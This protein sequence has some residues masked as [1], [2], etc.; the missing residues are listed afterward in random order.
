MTTTTPPALTRRSAGTARV[1]AAMEHLTSAQLELRRAAMDLGAVTGY[2]VEHGTIRSLHD[3]SRAA[4]NM[5]DDK[6]GGPPKGKTGELDRNPT[7]A[8][9]NA[10]EAG[11][12]ERSYGRAVLLV[13]LSALGTGCTSGDPDPGSPDA[14]PAALTLI[15]EV[16]P[17]PAYPSIVAGD[18]LVVTGGDVVVLARAWSAFTGYELELRTWAAAALAARPELETCLGQWADPPIVRVLPAQP[19]LLTLVVD[20]EG[21]ATLSQADWTTAGLY[22][23]AIISWTNGAAYSPCGGPA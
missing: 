12:G 7:E 21:D 10:H 11:C 16:G 22:R 20:A 2:A 8:D 14:E 6:I 15:E 23:S 1:R 13:V 9:R 3:Q 18:I 19:E 5:L 4:W 17:L